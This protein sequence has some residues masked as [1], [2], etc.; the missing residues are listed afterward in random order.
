MAIPDLELCS[1]QR[2]RLVRRAY[3]VLLPPLP[4]RL[5]RL[6]RKDETGPR[7]QPLTR[8]DT[9]SNAKLS[10]EPVDFMGAMASRHGKHKR[11]AKARTR[12]ES[13]SGSGSASLSRLSSL[14]TGIDG[15]LPLRT[16]IDEEMREDASLG[17]FRADHPFRMLCNKVAA[18]NAFTLLIMLTIMVS[19]VALALEPPARDS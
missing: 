15:N 2:L 6:F 4:K 5:K 16:G 13:G 1:H 11:L 14:A 7:L 17:L 19:M 9:A 12:F 18:S 10:S 3:R 8:K